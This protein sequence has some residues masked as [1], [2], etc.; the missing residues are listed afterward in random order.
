MSEREVAWE[1]HREHGHPPGY[2]G[3][4]WGP[5]FAEKAEARRVVQEWHRTKEEQSNDH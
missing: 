3:P 5:T 1:L 2:D 4:C